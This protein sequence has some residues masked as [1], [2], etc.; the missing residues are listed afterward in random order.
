[1]HRQPKLGHLRLCEAESK[2]E[3][4]AELKGEFAP[5]LLASR[6]HEIGQVLPRGLPILIA[7]IAV[8]LALI[9]FTVYLIGRILFELF[10]PLASLETFAQLHG[11]VH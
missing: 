9:F 2:T 8:T 3:G 6:P 1:L 10:K 7:V 4:G 5:P 11:R